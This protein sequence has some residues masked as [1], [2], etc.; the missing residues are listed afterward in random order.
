MSNES[1][2]VEAM[3]GFFLFVLWI[4]SP[5]AIGYWVESSTGSIT[6]AIFSGIIGGAFFP[7]VV[8]M[9]FSALT[10]EEKRG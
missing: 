6:L 1:E 7:A 8:M 3:G 10:S 5:L 9:I 2:A 4:A